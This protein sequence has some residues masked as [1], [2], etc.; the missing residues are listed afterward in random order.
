[1]IK[2]LI[3]DDHPLI[4]AGLINSLERNKEISVVGEAQDNDE[5]QRLV[6]E[7]RPDVVLLDIRMPGPS[8]LTTVQFI[9]SNFPETK[10]IILSAFDDEIYVRSLIPLGIAGYVLKDEVPDT[11]IRAITAVY[12][13]D[14]WYSH[15]IIEILAKTN[16]SSSMEGEAFLTRREME[17]LTQLA[18]GYDNVV[19]AENLSIAE[20]TVK[21]HIVSIYQK[22]GVHSRAEAVVKILES[23][24]LL[25][26]E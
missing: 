12:C 24:R 11:L 10:T 20:G 15:K 13:G 9:N 26:D 1:M 2:L 18:K 3:A 16:F 5:A 19:I 22:L 23:G 21:N 6:Q 25:L 17:V 4:R 8:V 7:L 14:T